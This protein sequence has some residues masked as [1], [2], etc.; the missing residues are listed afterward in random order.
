MAKATSSSRKRITD[1][2]PRRGR[3]R[4]VRLDFKAPPKPEPEISKEDIEKLKQVI[5]EQSIEQDQK[6][7][8]NESAINENL[9][10]RNKKI[11]ELEEANASLLK[12]I[13][14]L[15]ESNS[16]L[17]SQLDNQN[18]IFLEK[19]QQK[20]EQ[21]QKLL[22]EK[23]AFY[24]SKKNEEVSKIKSSVFE[25]IATSF[26]DPIILL[27]SIINSSP[28]DPVVANYLQGFKMLLN[29]FDEKLSDLGVDEINVNVGDPFN[30]LYMEAFD[31]VEDPNFPPHT[32]VKVVKKGFVVNESKVLKHTLVI[33]SK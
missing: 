32:V 5:S 18:S 1:T 4:Q 2:A 9:I 27:Q 22:D 3:Q 12:K 6:D 15:E 23:I 30:E 28:S 16:I 17:K 10:S 7:T 20:T 26:L 33:V 31:V 29:Q 24:E 13:K 8:S 14:I 21:A 25:E 11:I 19:I